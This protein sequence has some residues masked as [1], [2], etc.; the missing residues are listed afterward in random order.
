MAEALVQTALSDHATE[1]QITLLAISVSNLVDQPVLQLELATGAGR[2][3]SI[4]R[5][6]PSVRHAGRSINPST[7]CARRFGH[8]AVGYASIVLSEHR[9]VPDAFRE[10]AEHEL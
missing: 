2:P 4:R 5:L 9:S 8:A 6:A 7:P 1:R 10:L 3:P